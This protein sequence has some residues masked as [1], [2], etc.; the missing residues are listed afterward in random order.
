M[1]QMKQNILLPLLGL[2]LLASACDKKDQQAKNDYVITLDQQMIDYD[3]TMLNQQES[4]RIMA[5]RL[6]EKDEATGH[7]VFQNGDTR[8]EFLVLTHNTQGELEGDLQ[9]QVASGFIP[10]QTGP[11]HL[12]QGK[13]TADGAELRFEGT[14]SYHWEADSHTNGEPME[15]QEYERTGPFRIVAYNAYKPVYDVKLNGTLKDNYTGE[16]QTLKHHFKNAVRYDSDENTGEAWFRNADLDYETV[17][18]VDDIMLRTNADGTFTGTMRLQRFNAGNYVAQLEGK[19]SNSGDKQS[20]EGTFK[21]EAG[22]EG[23][24]LGSTGPLIYHY[25]GSGSFV[26]RPR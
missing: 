2:L 4:Q 11:I 18:N 9:F 12:N 10:G 5:V 15:H 23:N 19:V 26:M 17:P 13:V 21:I 14:F 6:V 3:G 25:E 24:P 8:G 20:Y 16:E 1:K 22:S 7:Y